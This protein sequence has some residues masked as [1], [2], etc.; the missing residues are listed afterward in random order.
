ME[1]PTVRVPGLTVLVVLAALA[2]IYLA[3]SFLLPI[4]FSLLLAFIASLGHSRVGPAPC[5]GAA[6]CRTHFV[7]VVGVDP[8][9]AAT[10]SSA[11]S[12]N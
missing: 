6:G 2:T 1:P 10:S 4:T 7:V 12:R 8:G 9:S 11:R 5:P 3:R